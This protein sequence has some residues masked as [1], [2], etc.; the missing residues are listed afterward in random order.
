[1]T[2]RKM[3]RRGTLHGFGQLVKTKTTH[4]VAKLSKTVYFKYFLLFILIYCV[5]LIPLFRANFNYIDDIGRVTEGYQFHFS[6]FTSDGLSGIVHD[7]GEFLADISPFTQLIAIVFLS[8][9]SVIAIYL[10]TEQKKDSKINLWYFCA[11]LPIGLSPY[12]MENMSYKFDSPYMALSILCAISP[13]IFY[14]PDK[15]PLGFMLAG[16]ISTIVVCTTYQSSTGIF[17]AMVILLALAMFNRKENWN[18]I[19]RFVLCAVGAYIAGMLIFRFFIMES[20]LESGY[21]DSDLIE[22]GNFVPGVIGH[23]LDYAKRFYNDFSTKWLIALVIIVVGFIVTNCINTKR[24]KCAAFFASILALVA[25][26]A[27]SFGVYPFIKQPIFEPRAMYGSFTSLA[28]LA[29]VAVDFK[30]A[31]L[32]KLCVAY[33]A[34]A[35]IVFAMAYGNA[36]NVQQTYAEYR[37]YLVANDLNSIYAEDSDNLQLD[38]DG[39][40]GLA[41]PV[42]NLANKKYPVIR[43]LVPVLFRDDDWVWGTAMFSYG[44]YP[45]NNMVRR[46]EELNVSAMELVCSTRLHDIYQDGEKVLVELK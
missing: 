28:L 44:H 11:A 38:V 32:P 14:H 3:D 37:I 4:T 36:L 27:L 18:D 46:T 41:P 30:K 34:Y 22:I 19:L 23:Y 12:F 31:Y 5:A 43:R 33:I 9:S 17:P 16:I 13:L 26:G 21:V 35:F 2:K 45:I 15:K 25:V 29:I 10:L 24:H 7:G 20:T 6:R 39:T 42:E 1:M 8:I 40:I